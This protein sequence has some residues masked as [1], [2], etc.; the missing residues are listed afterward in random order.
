M[1]KG[2]FGYLYDSDSA[3]RGKLKGHK[4]FTHFA[5]DNMGCF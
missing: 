4:G 2:F 3:E 5:G 1:K